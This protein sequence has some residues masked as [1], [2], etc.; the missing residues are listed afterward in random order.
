VLAVTPSQ[1]PTLVAK[2]AAPH[3]SQPRGRRASG[4]REPPRQSRMLWVQMAVDVQHLAR[5]G[6]RSLRGL[7]SVWLPAMPGEDSYA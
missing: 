6:H 7:P 3:I 5:L 1:P 4:I 2:P